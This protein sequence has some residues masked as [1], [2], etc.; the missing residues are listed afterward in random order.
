MAQRFSAADPGTVVQ[1]FNHTADAYDELNDALSF[2]LHR[3]WKR[4][5]TAALRPLRGE[6]VLDLCCGTGDLTMLLAERV[7]PN[8]RVVGIDVAAAPLAR[9]RQ[10]A[11]LTPWLPVAFQQADALDTPLPSGCFDALT[12]GYGLRNLGD[13]GA[14]LQEMRRLLKADGRAVVLDF[15]RSTNPLV[16]AFQQVYLREIVVPLAKGK[17]LEE[18]YAY[19]GP[20]IST[21]ASGAEQEHM[22][23]TAGFAAARHRPMAGGLMGLLDLRA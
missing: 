3:L 9:A 2:R 8:G 14:G 16:A 13:I 17:G 12:M 5:V 18:E 4:Q 1:L 7:R 10:R 15:N 21:F 11:A 20:S 23:R 19:L 22:A 6:R